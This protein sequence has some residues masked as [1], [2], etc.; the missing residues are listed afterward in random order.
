M[1][2]LTSDILFKRYAMRLLPNSKIL[3]FVLISVCI[4]T[5]SLAAEFEPFG[6]T[7]LR[8]EI[9][10]PQNA[11]TFDR[12]RMR[13]IVQGGYKIYINDSWMAVGRL[14]TGL[15]NKQNVP[16]ITIKRFSS[17]NQPDSDVYIDQAYMQYNDDTFHVKI[18]RVP[19][20][21]KAN[22]DTFWD[23][24]LNP[25]TIYVKKKLSPSHTF[26]A[27]LI[28]P[29]DGERSSVGDMFVSQYEYQT[30]T[31]NIVWSFQPWLVFYQGEVDALFATR[32]TAY[33]HHSARLSVSARYHSWSLGLDLSY[34]FNT[35]DASKT[36]TGNNDQNKSIVTELKKGSLKS[37]NDWQW[38]LRY[39]H[40]ERF[41]VIT[42]FAQNATAGV[43]ISNFSGWDTRFRYR[44]HP[45]IWIGTRLSIVQNLYGPAAKSNRFRVEGSWAF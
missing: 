34:A 44:V 13:L 3:A 6:M 39:M 8:Y 19:W 25:Y 28:K 33:D 16:A 24:H 26:S 15:K 7:V 32:D 1:V 31:S 36:H 10:S 22:T 5:V 37:V 11:N 2:T 18:G 41:S 38:H 14:S 43:L 30:S 4:S 45:D 12:E 20:S 17:Q 29:L 21:F 42:E 27:A 9:D 35:D 23:R 40:V